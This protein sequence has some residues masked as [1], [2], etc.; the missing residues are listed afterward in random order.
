MRYEKYYIGNT[1]EHK[2]L[3]V[4]LRGK[5]SAPNR[6]PDGNI[7]MVNETSTNNGIAKKASS[8]YVFQAP[9]ITVS[10]NY[11]QTVFL[12]E[13]DFCASVN[14]LILKSD[15]LTKMPKAGL[16]VV[17]HLI[18]NN[19][20]YDYSCKISKNRLNDTC[21]TLPTL[22]ELDENSPYSDEGFVPDFDYMQE[23]IAELEQERIE[24]LEQYLIATG[25]ND[26]ELTDKDKEIL[27]TK[28]IKGKAS[29]DSVSASGCWKEA[30]KFKVSRN[31]NEIGLFDCFRGTRLTKSNRIDGNIPLLTAGLGLGEGVAQNIKENDKL[32]KYSNDITIDMFGMCFYHDYEHYGDDNIHFLINDDIPGRSKLF[33]TQVL[34]KSLKGQFYYGRQFR[35]NFLEKM[36]IALPIQTDAE[37]NPI[38]DTDRKYHPD[39]YIPDWDFMEKYIRAI[40]KVVIADVVKYKDAVISKTKEIVA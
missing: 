26:Y 29:T 12:Q 13:E 21:I 28:L 20:K 34:E 23:R 27:A 5:E 18:K 30:R 33:I 25:L 4:Q 36:I 2:G 37:G 8:N 6:V 39:G 32:I 19:Q 31:H 3:F 9:A 7:N 17:P 1:P 15:W 11:A 22:D 35:M 14:I 24:E 10:V 38:I 16:Y 40:E